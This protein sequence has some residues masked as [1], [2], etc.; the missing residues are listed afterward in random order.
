ME[1]P[2]VQQMNRERN[3][4]DPICCLLH[5]FLSPLFRCVYFACAAAA[6]VFLEGPDA[7]R[8]PFFFQF[9]LKANQTF[10]QV[11]YSTKC[12]PFQPFFGFLLD[13]WHLIKFTAF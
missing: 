5:Y 1:F 10:P 6:G 3:K 12:S 9:T 13:S 8:F 7:Q 11:G 2:D 4:G